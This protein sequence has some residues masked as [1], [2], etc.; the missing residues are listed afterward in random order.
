MLDG[1]MSISVEYVSWNFDFYLW[2][3]SPYR[4]E[5]IFASPSWYL[6]WA[7]TVLNKNET[8]K[9]HAVAPWDAV[10][11]N[12]TRV[13]RHHFKCLLPLES[14]SSFGVIIL[15]WGH[16]WVTMDFRIASRLDFTTRLRIVDFLAKA[17]YFPS[18]LPRDQSFLLSYNLLHMNFLF[19]M[20]LLSW[21][22]CHLSQIST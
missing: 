1:D 22:N 21:I 14:H 3:S 9:G 18:F 8:I 2:I 19:L 13:G 11:S 5:K 15:S 20:E 4:L 10:E 12:L 6:L 16:G 7:E 17:P